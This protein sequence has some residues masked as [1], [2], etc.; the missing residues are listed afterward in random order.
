MVIGARAQARRAAR[1][2]LARAYHSRVRLTPHGEALFEQ[3]EQLAQIAEVVSG[4][5]DRMRLGEI[6]RLRL[7]CPQLGQPDTRQ[8]A[9]IRR[10]S[11]A[12]PDIALAVEPGSVDIHLVLVQRGTLVFVLTVLASGAP[13][14]EGLEGVP[15]YPV[16]LAAMMHEPFIFR[17]PAQ[18]WLGQGAQVQAA[19]LHGSW[20]RIGDCLRHHTR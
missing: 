17:P 4:E 13:L 12:N 11:A 14:G 9:L 3:V 2:H 19:P 10:F 6:G 16:I 8:A 18:S 1:C 20:R 7:G 15:L 5:V